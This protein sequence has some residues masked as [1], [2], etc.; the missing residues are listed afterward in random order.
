[1]GV[2]ATRHTS[3]AIK[4]VSAPRAF[5]V[6]FDGFHGWEGAVEAPLFGGAPEETVKWDIGD[7]RTTWT[8]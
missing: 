6:D 5:R 1:M 2:V 4:W 7:H 8:C 3:T